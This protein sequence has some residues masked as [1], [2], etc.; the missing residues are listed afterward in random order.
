MI[1]NVQ[2]TIKLAILLFSAASC[3]SFWTESSDEQTHALERRQNSTP[4][5]MVPR[6]NGVNVAGL[7]FGVDINGTST[8][9]YNPPDLSQVSHFIGVGMN[10]IRFSFGWQYIQPTIKGELDAKYLALLDKYV[11]YTVD[12]NV[13]VIIDLHN[14]A[15][16]DGKI[17][18]QSELGADTLVDLWSKLASHFKDQPKVFFGVMN[19]PHDVDSKTWIGVVQQVVTAIRQQGAANTI[20]LPGNAWMHFATFADDYNL[21]LGSVKNP[22]GTTTGLIF[23]IHQY[24]DV[25]G[26][27]SHS[28][29]TQYH[30][31]EITAVAALLKRDG[32][33]AIITETGGGNTQSC[34]D[35]IYK[36]IKAVNHEYPSL[37]GAMMWGGGAFPADNNL[38][39]TVKEGND[40][41]DQINFTAFKKALTSGSNP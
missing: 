38:V 28:E 27:G 35:F 4:P 39:I 22:D 41:K 8:G 1:F 15:R 7:E 14:Y 37:I 16:R 24:L 18:G 19:E 29:C 26:S 32:R 13:H 5:G 9:V 31:D 12:S 25:D 23:D 6:M 2:M 10:I 30:P 20:L 11:K 36:F 34:S 3:Q 40:W 33:Q 21:G 17:V